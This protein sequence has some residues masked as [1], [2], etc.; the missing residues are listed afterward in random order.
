MQNV[1]GPTLQGQLDHLRS[2][3]FNPT[4]VY[5][6]PQSMLRTLAMKFENVSMDVEGAGNF[7][8]KVNAKIRIKERC[9]SIKATLKWN[10][11]SI[12]VKD[13]VAYVISRINIE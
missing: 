9:R 8:P 4:H 10:L 1:L 7:V 3:G 6:D 5:I 13:L 2:K 12:M 11:P